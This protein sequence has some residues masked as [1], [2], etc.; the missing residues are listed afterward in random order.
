MNFALRNFQR[1][2]MLK[3]NATRRGVIIAPTGAGKT[4][5]GISCISMLPN[6]K[7]KVLV[8]VP[9]IS[10]AK[11][12]QE[13]IENAIDIYDIAKHVYMVGDGI[14][15]Q[16]IE[17]RIE[18]D[19]SNLVIVI[20]VVNSI[21]FK[22]L[23]FDMVILDEFHKFFSRCNNSFLPISEFTAVLGLTATLKA[24]KLRE[25]EFFRNLPIVVEI[26]HRDVYREGLICN[27]F[28]RNVPLRFNPEQMTK[29]LEVSQTLK[30]K[31]GMFNFNF[32]ILTNAAGRGDVN[33]IIGMRAVTGRKKLLFDAPQRLEAACKIINMHA[34]QKIIVFSETIDLCESIANAVKQGA[35]RPVFVFHSQLTTDEKKNVIKEFGAIDNS[36]LCCVKALDEGMNV[37]SAS[38]GI[39]ASGS[40]TRRQFI[41]RL[42]RVIRGVKGKTAYLYQLYFEGTKDRDWLMS[43]TADMDAT[44][45]NI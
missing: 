31:L 32:G 27:F 33:A 39:I 21:R 9:T 40:S 18:A 30:T 3:W 44:I 19:I 1:L 35:S 36:V 16:D 23:K 24:E 10:L 26:S 2:A 14:S 34:E 8:V 37:P 25:W 38:V 13:E 43:R 22:R 7:N 20:A 6:D 42:G 5:I 4:F 28:V 12:W 45:Y 41:Q 15:L 29:Y 11:Q 17:M